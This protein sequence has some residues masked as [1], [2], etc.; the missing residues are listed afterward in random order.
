M[1]QTSIT[2]AIAINGYDLAMNVC[3]NGTTISLDNAHEDP[4]GKLQDIFQD[5]LL[6]HTERT[7]RKGQIHAIS[8]ILNKPVLRRQIYRHRFIHQYRSKA[9]SESL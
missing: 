2:V 5:A 9:T 6:Y 8:K 4:F 3:V 1:K 7:F